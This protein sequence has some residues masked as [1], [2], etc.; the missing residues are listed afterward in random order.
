MSQTKEAGQKRKLDHVD[1]QQHLIIGKKTPV[2]Q[3]NYEVSVAVKSS[4]QQCYCKK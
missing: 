3:M 4:C 2:N 1:S